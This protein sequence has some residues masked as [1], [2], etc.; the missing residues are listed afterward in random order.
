M[1][2]SLIIYSLKMN[3]KIFH[4]HEVK[5][6]NDIVDEPSEGDIIIGGE[7]GLD[8][9]EELFEETQEAGLVSEPEIEVEP[10]QEQEQELE[11]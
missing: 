8:V 4:F 2:M 7:L 1:M 3:P 10:E 5:D 11:P 6:N 9:S